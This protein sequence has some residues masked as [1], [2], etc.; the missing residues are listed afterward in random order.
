LTVH[1]LVAAPLRARVWVED[2]IAATSLQSGDVELLG[3]PGP[4]D[5]FARNDVR[6]SAALLAPWANRLAL[7][8]YPI[9]TRVA[10]VAATGDAS[11][12]DST[13]LAIHGFVGRDPGWVVTDADRDRL[14]AERRWDVDGPLWSAFPVQ[15]VTRVTVSLSPRTL[16]IATSLIALTDDA[17]PAAFGWHPYL[18]PPDGPRADW[19]LTL[20]R[21]RR[22][23]TDARGLPIRLSAERAAS[24]R[25]LADR[26]LDDGYAVE[27][28][29][30]A[31]LTSQ[32][33]SLTVRL[34]RGYR[35]LQVYAPPDRDVVCLEP[36][37]APTNALVSCTRV[38][39]ARP[40]APFLAGFSLV[41]TSSSCGRRSRFH[42]R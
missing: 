36:M 21:A 16:A 31:S 9:G 14:T 40:G 24:R 6:L 38:P 8:R 12:R 33:W 26:A 39:C 30:R 25:R 13:G 10:D 27:P 20:P 19:V 34:D 15:H 5:L 42:P 7:D 22:W 32:A 18:A 35:A 2:G 29:A 1:E 17:V 28:G 23:T 11:L 41:V 3:C 37:C 4:L